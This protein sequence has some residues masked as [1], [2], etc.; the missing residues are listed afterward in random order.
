MPDF[1]PTTT[2]LV[3]MVPVA[4]G[5]GL[6]NRAA[7]GLKA[8]SKRRRRIAPSKPIRRRAVK[9]AAPKRKIVPKRK[10]R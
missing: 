10:R 5:A 9:R 8:R 2:A 6:V 4:V 1:S 3:G 7:G